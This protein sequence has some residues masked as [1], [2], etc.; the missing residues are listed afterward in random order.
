MRPLILAI[1]LICFGKNIFAQTMSERIST[2]EKRWQVA[3]T[4]NK[5]INDT[6]ASVTYDICVDSANIVKYLKLLEQEY[7]KYPT[8]YFRQIN[9]HTIILAQNLKSKGVNRPALPDP[10]SKNIYFS[11]DGSQANVSDTYLIHTMHHELSHLEEYSIWGEMYYKW[12]QWQM[13]NTATFHYGTDFASK[14]DKSTNWLAPIHPEKGFMNYYS[15]I[16]EGEDRCEIIALIMCDDE[17]KTLIKF[18]KE[19]IIL[20]EKI[21]L[22]SAV[23]NELSGT[24]DNYWTNKMSPLFEK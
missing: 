8:N 24:T 12:D 3:I 16:N 20:C 5:V 6:W 13:L 2:L 22:I 9:L 17:R 14:L 11:I 1:V 4:Y 21:K 7:S 18:G 15:M 10:F 19:D 23:L